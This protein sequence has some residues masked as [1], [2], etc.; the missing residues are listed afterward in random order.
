MK[1][2]WLYLLLTPM[3]SLSASYSI[4]D[5]E[6]DLNYDLEEHEEVVS[7]PTY[8]DEWEQEIAQEDSMVFEDEAQEEEVL[9]APQKRSGRTERNSPAAS[10]KQPN[11]SSKRSSAKSGRSVQGAT[12][13]RS[14]LRDARENSNRPRVTQRGQKSGSYPNA[15]QIEAD[16]QMEEPAY[17]EPSEP[18][19]NPPSKS[20][21]APT[22]S[23]KKTGQ[24]GQIERRSSANQRAIKAKSYRKSL[25]KVEKTVKPHPGKRPQGE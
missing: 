24:T 9:A 1:K 6:Y 20:R 17:D 7:S 11:A 13:A 25:K 21:K 5:E 22:A 23:E 19:R 10:K 2:S 12:S 18:S 15:G 16:A 8:A 14:K 4:Y 3:I